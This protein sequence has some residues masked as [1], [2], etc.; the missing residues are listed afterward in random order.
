MKI[1]NWFEIPAADLARAEAFYEGVLGVTLSNM[2][3]GPSKMEM[4]PFEQGAAG[5]GGTLIS[6]EGYTPSHNGTMVYFSVTDI[7]VTLGKIGEQGGKT[8]VPKMSIGEHGFVA[9]FED[10]EGNRVGLHSPPE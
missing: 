10:T 9:H 2:E 8:L 1:S 4:F 5:A 6:A 3:M 7:E